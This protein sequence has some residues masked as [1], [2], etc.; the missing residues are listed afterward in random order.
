MRNRQVEKQVAAQRGITLLEIMIVL[1]IIGLVMGV[2]VG[3]A[4]FKALFQAK[5]DIARAQAKQLAGKTYQMWTHDH[6]GSCPERIED[7]AKYEG[8]KELKD[9]WG[10]PYTMRC[11]GL[12]E[13]VPFGIVSAG[14]D[15]KEGTP[16]DINSWED[17]KGKK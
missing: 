5:E 14:P 9:P 6:D 7:L 17:S 12:P 11:E 8:K 4:V 3:P 2:F 16:D 13:D 15:K 1:T 10:S